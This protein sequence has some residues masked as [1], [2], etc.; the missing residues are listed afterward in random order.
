MAQIDFELQGE[1]LQQVYANLVEA[2]SNGLEMGLSF[3]L[4]PTRKP[5]SSDLSSGNTV[6]LPIRV[7]VILPVLVAM[8]LQEAIAAQL[9]LIEALP[10]PVLRPAKAE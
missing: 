5:A 10:G 4:M 2:S 8:H 3:A 9:K 7:Q 6:T 1:P